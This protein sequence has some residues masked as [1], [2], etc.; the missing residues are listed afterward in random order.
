MNALDGYAWGTTLTIDV[1]LSLV[2]T[3]YGLQHW[4][5]VGRA[6]EGRG[7]VNIFSYNLTALYVPPSPTLWGKICAEPN[8]IFLKILKTQISSNLLTF[9][10]IA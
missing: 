10:S 1:Y 5:G 9:L 2:I 3:K 4:G 6:V 7:R 8:A